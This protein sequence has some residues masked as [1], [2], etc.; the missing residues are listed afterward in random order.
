MS[1]RTQYSPFFPRIFSRDGY[2]HPSVSI[3]FDQERIHF[4][5]DVSQT[6]AR[7]LAK[8]LAESPK[9]L[10][11]LPD[12][13]SPLLFKVAIQG[14]YLVVNTYRTV[15]VL[16]RPSDM[17]PVFW[18]D[19]RADAVFDFLAERVLDGSAGT[20]DEPIRMTV[21]HITRPKAGVYYD[22]DL[23]YSS[24][25]MRLTDQQYQVIRDLREAAEA[26]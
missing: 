21:E 9:F 16:N 3:L 8:W 2:V 26:A 7:Y 24:F 20:T 15:E 5:S 4:P 6:M 10:A 17:R 22:Y 14:E 11:K 23:P 25:Q 13:R 12:E 19:W 18:L 1:N